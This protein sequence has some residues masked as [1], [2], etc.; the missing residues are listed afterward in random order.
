VSVREQRDVALD[1]ARPGDHPIGSRTDLLRRFTARASIPEDEP[2][3]CLFVDLRGRQP[4]VLPVIPLD[5][6]GIDDGRSARPDGSQVSAPLQ[7]A[8]EAR[9]NASRA[10]RRP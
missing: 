6:V 3:R 1:G 10:R 5:E 8:R 2:A 7:R 4:L 9:A